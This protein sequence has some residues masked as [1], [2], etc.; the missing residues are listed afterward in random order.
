MVKL[1]N[2]IRSLGYDAAGLPFKILGIVAET[3]DTGI[4][5]IANAVAARVL[6]EEHFNRGKDSQEFPRLSHEAAFTSLSLQLGVITTPWDIAQ[7]RRTF[8]VLRG[9][10]P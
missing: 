6:E 9:Q 4:A 10:C 7:L 5:L 3:H 1:A 2:R 8:A